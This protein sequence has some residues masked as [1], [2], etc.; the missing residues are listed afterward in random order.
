MNNSR[1]N[2]VAEI[3]TLTKSEYASAK[4]I[5]N[6]VPLKRIEPED[7]DLSRP[8]E[9]IPKMDTISSKYYMRENEEAEIHSSKKRA[10]VR[11]DVGESPI[12][13]RA[14][15]DQLQ[16]YNRVI[17]AQAQE[18]EYFKEEI[19]RLQEEKI[20][21][22]QNYEQ[23]LV[24]YRDQESYKYELER[25]VRIL[26]SEK[27]TL[28][29]DLN[30]FKLRV[31]SLEFELE[32]FRRQN[33]TQHDLHSKIEE[34]T[35]EI[36]YYE[37]QMK[38]ARVI[39]ISLEQELRQ[40]ADERALLI[41][42]YEIRITNLQNDLVL[43]RETRKIEDS[44][45]NQALIRS[46]DENINLSNE[47][48]NLRAVTRELQNQIDRI[49][50]DHF[51]S[52]ISLKKRINEFENINSSSLLAA[53]KFKQQSENSNINK[54][55]LMIEIDRLREEV[56]QLKSKESSSS[57]TTTAYYISSPKP[58]EE[59]S[60]RANVNKENQNQSGD[61]KEKLALETKSKNLEQ[62]NAQHENKAIL[63]MIE[64]ERL[65]VIVQELQ[66]ENTL[67][68]QKTVDLEL[69]YQRQI[70]DFQQQYELVI[71][72]QIEAEIRN[73][74]DSI[75][76]EKKTLELEIYD[77]K[78]EIMKLRNEI[79]TLQSEASKAKERN[80]ELTIK[81]EETITSYDKFIYQNNEAKRSLEEEFRLKS[82][83]H[84]E[85]TDLV[86]LQER[87]GHQREVTLYNE[88]IR[89]L[90]NRISSLSN[91]INGLQRNLNDSEEQINSLK[92]TLLDTENER[93][94]QLE[95]LRTTFKQTYENEM[96]L[97]VMQLEAMH[98]SLEDQLLKSKEEIM[99]LGEQNSILNRETEQLVIENTEK[100]ALIEKYYLE[101]AHL[102]EQNQEID[103]WRQKHEQVQTG[104]MQEA[105]QREVHFEETLKEHIEHNLKQAGAEKASLEAELERLQQ[106]NEEI[107]YNQKGLLEATL[108]RL[109]QENEE[110]LNNQRIDFETQI[111]QRE[112]IFNEER[113]S[114]Q[115]QLDELQKE[116]QIQREYLEDAKQREGYFE[117][118]FNKR[119]ETHLKE[120]HQNFD[121][122]KADLEA[123]L[124][125]VQQEN[126]EILHNQ[127]ID[128]ETQIQQ[129]E[130]ALADER[131]SLKHL[132][133]E[134]QELQARLFENISQ[135][136]QL[137][138]A[139][140]EINKANQSLVLERDNLH[141]DIEK[142]QVNLNAEIE[143][144]QIN[145]ET[146]IR[147]NIEIEIENVS[148]KYNQEK[149]EIEDILLTAQSEAEDLRVKAILYMA[150]IE[151]LHTI[152][153][154]I[155]KEEDIWRERIV[156]LENQNAIRLE[157]QKVEYEDILRDKLVTEIE[158]IQVKVQHEKTISEKEFNLL[159]N[160]Y[161]ELQDS[162]NFSTQENSRLRNES[163]EKE[164]E[165]HRLSVRLSTLTHEQEE[166][167]RG[168][169]SGIQTQLRIDFENQIKDITGRFSNEKIAFED[170]IRQLKNR[171]SE[172][173][174]KLG[175]A[176]NQNE[177]LN[178]NLEENYNEMEILRNRCF[179]LEKEVV[180]SSQRESL[181]RASPQKERENA[182]LRAQIQELE[183]K[184]QEY[185]K[186]LALLTTEIE[187]ISRINLDLK[188]EAENLRIK[189]E[190]LERRSQVEIDQTKI[191]LEM[192]FR[193][194]RDNMSKDINARYLAEIKNYDAQTMD[195]RRKIIDYESDMSLLTNEIQRLSALLSDKNEE[196]EVW[197][198]RTKRSE[199]SKNQELY[200]IT[201]KRDFDQRVVLEQELRNL[202][203]HFSIEKAQYDF[204][205]KD[206]H[207]KNLDYENKIVA[208]S[209]ELDKF[210]SLY[211]EKL[212]EIESIKR[213]IATNPEQPN[214][215]EFEEMRIHL[216]TLK[217]SSLQI[218]DYEIR[219]QAE[220]TAYEAQIMQ[221]KHKIGELET[222][223]VDITRESQRLSSHLR[224]SGIEAQQHI[225]KQSGFI[226][227][228][229]MEE[230]QK[231][232]RENEN[233]KKLLLENQEARV[234]FE[235]ER[236]DYQS[237]VVQLKQIIEVN[238]I[239][240]KK[241]YGLLESRKAENEALYHDLNKTREEMTKNLREFKGME[242]E[243]NFSLHKNKNVNQ[244][245]EDLQ[246]A[247]DMYRSQLEKNEIELT[248]KN[249][250][251]L[252]KICQ[253]DILKIKYEEAIANVDPITSTIITRISTTRQEI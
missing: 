100:A 121:N 93:I 139:L 241:L 76:R 21:N 220:R 133:Q 106:E 114:F 53:E 20:L 217:R 92:N 3:Q 182:A 23:R 40:R 16:H 179:E 28:E 229:D 50:D 236:T 199:Q 128:F 72:P 225:R 163:I 105:K 117:E 195:L 137:Q 189:A 71:R 169:K 69:D 97:K 119:L 188:G 42:E 70:D 143:K 192:Q 58:F 7:E 154:E 211:E 75:E 200:E 10:M 136:E 205:I 41:S 88:R 253:I 158:K 86:L 52:E 132:E 29:D 239:E 149:R 36:H 59:R 194:E 78:S 118:S 196:L 107:A 13:I 232:Q 230:H 5:P 167:V 2:F 129:L 173:E 252:E 208:I 186:D 51:Q 37:N 127:R 140:V 238:Q 120:L 90:E 162:L 224:E 4:L 96:G 47:N 175:I 204:K 138:K 66:A 68:R 172:I 8:I 55:L 185:F 161:K 233:L 73:T 251:L 160:K 94:Y 112:H 22:V 19:R 180:L 45:Q 27:A 250:E 202:V 237:Q 156:E 84:Q 17:E 56:A 102:K 184:N 6:A 249:K 81:L 159:R 74:T 113:V 152:I 101:I 26:E 43:H 190:S 221:Y 234:R 248:L 108:E 14:S 228:V 201:Q 64:I 247:R 31:S 219:F 125:R 144:M 116:N 148:I 209:V 213:Q 39:Q 170:Q 80:I 218:S 164:D 91:Q 197:K 214:F 115:N 89:E 57:T 216:E 245:I 30:R 79:L 9:P 176:Q 181:K 95:Q 198:E 178:Q 215:I 240:M 244:E 67:L 18:I 34:L 226:G 61:I 54:V 130:Q 207:Q 187:R 103:V 12:D 63:F 104:F 135:I 46:R 141:A 124:Q 243:Y 87:Q 33:A 82:A 49:R 150:E 206:L 142:M 157:E 153:F 212:Q 131:A 48:K 126:E 231:V 24:N 177:A 134:N 165:M 223:I 222:I 110:V 151:R 35:G 83:R 171:I 65:G 155:E 99:Y 62:M 98:A 147:Q 227:M 166:Y 11:S 1:L 25:K 146:Q 191:K 168:L 183:T 174:V 122:Q 32:Q 109:Q 85:G 60:K 77:H 44:D 210:R 235:V 38:Q 242:A 123:E 15:S 203:D 111:Q 145:F 246:N 193:E